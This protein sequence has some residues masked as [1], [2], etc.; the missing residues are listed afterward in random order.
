MLVLC[1][2]TATPMVSAALVRVP[3][4]AAQPV[5]TVACWDRL[6]PRSHGELLAPAVRDLLAG[7]Q[8]AATDL[9]AVAVGLGPGPFTSL[10]VGIV[11]AAAIALAAGRPAYGACS[12]DLIAA[13][14]GG[15]C[16]V[17]SDARRRE[18]Y[19]ARYDT[20]LHRLQGPEVARPTVVAAQLQP[21]ERVVGTD[22][23][24]DVLPVQAVLAAQARHLGPL[25][26]DRVR[27]GA[28]GEVLH[29]LYLRRPDAT[30]VPG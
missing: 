18:V 23:Y 27:A 6:G 12:L 5:E 20:A 7:A 30:P 8:L 1:L 28:P 16:L 4:A 22:L 9:T 26:A 24:P 17:T 15:G 19:W 11:T 13:E 14:A 21:G 29:P 25:V 2:D 10:R 3:A